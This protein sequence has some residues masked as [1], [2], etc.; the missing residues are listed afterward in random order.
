M[1]LIEMVNNMAK[2]DWNKSVSQDKL[3]NNR[4]NCNTHH[5]NK[6][7]FNKFGGDANIC[8]LAQKCFNK[9]KIDQKNSHLP[10]DELWVISLTWATNI[11]NKK[12]P[13]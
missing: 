7:P 10:P 12:Q 4:L 2:I 1:F 3:E 9:M 11:I 8:N 5:V 6:N 13:D